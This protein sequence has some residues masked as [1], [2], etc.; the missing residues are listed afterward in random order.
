[1]VKYKEM[2]ENWRK[3]EEIRL[4]FIIAATRVNENYTPVNIGIAW[5]G[6]N[7]TVQIQIYPT[8]V[9]N[10]RIMTLLEQCG[11]GTE[12]LEIYAIRVQYSVLEFHWTDSSKQPTK[13]WLLNLTWTWNQE[14]V[15][16]SVLSKPR[17]KLTKAIAAENL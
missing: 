13:D 3:F 4:K 6:R 11:K 5:W 15:W 16:D 12:S 17:S 1:M 7:K 14:R 10:R 8:V 9:R 2:E